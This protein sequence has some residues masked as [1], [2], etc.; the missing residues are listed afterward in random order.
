[1]YKLGLV[2]FSGAAAIHLVAGF[3]S[4]LAA[5]LLKPRLGRKEPLAIKRGGLSK[6]IILSH[7]QKQWV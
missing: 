3:S 6:E 2:D 4:L 1:M 5:A 7:I